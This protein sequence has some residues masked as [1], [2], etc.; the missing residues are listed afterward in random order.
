MKKCIYFFL[1]AASAVIFSAVYFK[2]FAQSLSKCSQIGMLF[3]ILAATV[4]LYCFADRYKKIRLDYKQIF[5]HMFVFMVTAQL[6]CGY[7]L[8]MD[9]ST[10]DIYAVDRG[11]R[12]LASGKDYLNT[13]YFARYPNNTAILLV[14]SLVYKISYTL[15]G[16]T[17][18][19]VGILFNIAA[20]D[21][22]V[23]FSVKIA[24]ILKDDNRFK[25]K[26]GIV[27]ALFLPFYL[28]VPIY[29]TDTLSMPV[30]TGICYFVLL[31]AKNI[32]NKIGSAKETYIRCVF[33]GILAA[34]GF[35]LKGSLII[36]TVAFLIYMF[37][38]LSVRNFA[39]V[40]VSCIAGFF[41][42]LLMWG[43][44]AGRVDLITDEQYDQ[45]QFPTAHWIMMG[46]TGKG[47]YNSED[48]QYTLSFPT[49]DEKREADISVIKSRLEKLGP[50]GLVFHMYNK[51]TE[52]TWNYGTFFAER[53]IGDAGDKPHRLN[54]LHQFVLT[55]GAHHKELYIYSQGFYLLILLGCII[56]FWV[57]LVFFKREKVNYEL[58]MLQVALLGCM[59]FFMIWETHPRYILHF[60]NIIVLIGVYQWD[61]ITVNLKRLILKL[62]F[63]FKIIKNK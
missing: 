56:S 32:A 30:L 11:A 54:A 48:V 61:K 22:S 7:L 21:L 31:T 58:F 15:F 45:N 6:F 46:L 24:E 34:F 5:S 50:S 53:Y 8:K 1:T 16:T 4:L 37:L 17:S 36:I 62:K 28:Y 29:Y 40:S 33:I 12:F 49:Y 55:E 44:I 35:K 14:L 3:F 19:Y 27:S 47:S 20:I 23:L 52:Y 39:K 57:S 41:A 13:A 18:I 25:Y 2:V 60:S 10:W 38:K 43:F 26:V 9:F 51:A 42:V 59:L 63:N